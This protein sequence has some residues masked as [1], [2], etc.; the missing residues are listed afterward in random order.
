MKII[1]RF[2][3]FVMSLLPSFAFSE[4]NQLD[5]S[6]KT[7]ENI[8]LITESIKNDP[9]LGMA[10]YGGIA[11]AAFVGLIVFVFILIMFLKR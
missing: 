9:S 7:K 5:K 6:Y 11:V 8:R 10:F 4:V 2:C 1:H 3:Y